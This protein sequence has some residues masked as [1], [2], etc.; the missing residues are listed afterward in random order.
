MVVL[1]FHHY[2]L[3]IIRNIFLCSNFL[4]L[5]YNSHFLICYFLPLL[6]F[7]FNIIAIIINYFQDYIRMMATPIMWFE[8]FLN[9][10]FL[11]HPLIIQVPYKN[12]ESD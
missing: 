4:P 7:R 11:Y 3:I 6:H 12:Y 9:W 8:I 1:H 2:Y 5:H 10:Y